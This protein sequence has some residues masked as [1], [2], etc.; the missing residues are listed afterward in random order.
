[1]RLDEG[2]RGQ[3]LSHLSW[4]AWN[5]TELRVGLLYEKMCLQRFTAPACL[6]WGLAAF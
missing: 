5:G 6:Y 2:L 1:M 3:D 4:P